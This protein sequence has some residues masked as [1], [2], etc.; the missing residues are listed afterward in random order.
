MK[1]RTL[2]IYMILLS[3]SIA[4]S[5]YLEAGISGGFSQYF[6]DLQYG[7]E[8]RENNAT[9]GI[10]ARY[11]LK[12]QVALKAHFSQATLS[13]TDATQRQTNS[14]ESNR[15]LSFQSKLYEL[16][17]QGE[18]NITKFDIRDD[19]VTAPYLFAGIAGIYNN[20]RAEL[21]GKWYDLQSMGT[22]GQTLE[23]GKKYSKVNVAFPVGVGLKVSLSERIN[24]GFEFGL[25]LTTSDYLDDVSGTYPNLALLEELNPIASQLSFRSPE[26]LPQ[27]AGNPVGKPRGNPNDKD[28]YFIGNIT[29][30]FNLVEG[31]DLEFDE[32]LRKFSPNYKPKAPKMPSL[33]S[34]KRELRKEEKI[35]DKARS[36]RFGADAKKKKKK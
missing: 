11:N 1:L 23:G 22:E 14:F 2:F 16:A 18:W 36:D 32:R 33:K 34:S 10:F 25:R 7:Y 17:I 9:F 28:G 8:A 31:Y 15:N 4:F 20:P 26:I 30:S 27:L 6:G 5:Q 13:G 12:R 21:D 24:I 3:P 29:F 35:R 19:Q